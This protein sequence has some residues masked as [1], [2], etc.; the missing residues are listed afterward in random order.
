MLK[1]MMSLILNAEKN[2]GKAIEEAVRILKAGGII[3]YPT[4]SFYALGALTFNEKAVKRIF[5]LKK[6]P[7][8]KPLPLIVDDIQ[9]L[10]TVA[11][12][13]PDQAM[14]LIEKFWPGPLTM[15]LRA[16]SEVPSLITGK[17][18]KVAV[19]IPGD[20]IALEIVKAARASVTATSANISSF[21]PASDTD[22][23]VS[24]FNENL[25]L[26]LDGGSSPGGPP[27]TIIDVTVK[28]LKVLRAGRIKLYNYIPK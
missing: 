4:E 11:K 15:L 18:G 6:R 7:C 9:I 8:E 3:A 27:S 19:R 26:I 2:F 1:F 20:G 5:D 28:P 16:R 25:D 12:E 22:A 24:Y 21:P 10:L 23:V 17:S 14:E 13:V